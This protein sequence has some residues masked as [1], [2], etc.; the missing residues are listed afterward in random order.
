MP[1]FLFFDFFSKM[2]PY[3]NKLNCIGFVEI[4]FCWQ[5]SLDHGQFR[6]F[7]A[8][9]GNPLYPSLGPGTCSSEPTL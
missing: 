9:P 2:V 5:N 1:P 7:K 6:T 8:I 4:H 3:M